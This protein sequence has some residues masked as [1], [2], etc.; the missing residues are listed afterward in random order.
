MQICAAGFLTNEISLWAGLTR[1][2]RIWIKLEI[3]QQFTKHCSPFYHSQQILS[4]IRLSKFIFTWKPHSTIISL[5][6][7][8][9]WSE[10]RPSPPVSRVWWSCLVWSPPSWC[11]RS[12][13]PTPPDTPPATW[14]SPQW[15]SSGGGRCGRPALGSPW[16]LRAV[17][18]G[19]LQRKGHEMKQKYRDVINKKKYRTKKKKKLTLT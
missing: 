2:K 7:L 5:P 8:P 6:F 15:R 16:V 17:R 10:L 18:G 12:I 4:K 1:L 13:W 14:T 9:V 11:W 3:L 19:S